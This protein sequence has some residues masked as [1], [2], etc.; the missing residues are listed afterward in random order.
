MDRSQ[1]AA[2]VRA[3]ARRSG[4]EPHRALRLGRSIASCG[5]RKVKPRGALRGPGGDNVKRWLPPK[6]P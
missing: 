4:A 5:E 1:D 3:Q 6:Q 2:R